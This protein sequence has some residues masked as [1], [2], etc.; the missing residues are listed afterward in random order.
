MTTRD[1]ATLPVATDAAAEVDFVLR[2]TGLPLLPEERE[3]FIRIYPALVASLQQIRLP[4]TRDAE[5]SLIF[6]ATFDR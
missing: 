4:E 6:P 5:P 1:D 2:R 3:R